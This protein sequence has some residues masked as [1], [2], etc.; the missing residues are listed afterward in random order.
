MRDR[1]GNETAAHRPERPHRHDEADADLPRQ[2][3]PANANGWNRT[4][5]QL[6]F[7]PA[8]A[9]SGVA[10]TS[11]PSP[12]T[13][14]TEGAV[15]NGSVSVTDIAGNSADFTSPS[16]MIDKTAPAITFVSRLPA[17][18][19]NGWNNTDITSK[20]SCADGLSGVVAANLSHT[21]SSEGANQSLT[22]TCADLADN[23]TADTV[24]ALSLDKTA[25]VVQC[26]ADRRRYLPAEQQDGAGG[27]WR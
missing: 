7:I 24:G 3:P 13:L 17:A 9:L 8:D 10:S 27:R 14:S 15:I 21:L 19:E 16:V 1:A 4:D 12:L 2:Q 23:T 18:N 11:I 5:V 20:W 26:V 6:P 22:G 25:P